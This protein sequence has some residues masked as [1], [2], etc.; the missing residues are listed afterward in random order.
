MPLTENVD[1]TVR[2]VCFPNSGNAAAVV[3]NS[4]GT[5]TVFLNTRFD[6]AALAQALRHELRHLEENDF[7]SALPIAE[8]EARADG[9]SLPPAEGELVP[10]FPS[11]D[12]LSEW[13][14]CQFV[15]NSLFL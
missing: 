12:A 9:L 4:D 3:D 2:R 10:F 5:F 13:I 14:C 8:I 7:S 11:E 6:E 1:Y 15:I